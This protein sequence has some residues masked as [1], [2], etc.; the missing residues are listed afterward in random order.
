MSLLN[1]LIKKNSAERMVELEDR[2]KR[3]AV[4]GDFEGSVT[5][6]WVKLERSG[7]GTVSYNN[8]HYATNP[9]GLTSVPAGAVV[10]LS[11]AN[12]VYFSKF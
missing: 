11:H 9:I 3:T 7:I 2:S 1:N 8:K 12:G 10:E 6:Y 4:R 5:G